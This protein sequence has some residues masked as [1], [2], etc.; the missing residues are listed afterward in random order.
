MSAADLAA[1][2]NAG[3]PQ[4]SVGILTADLGRMADELVHTD[5]MDGVFCPML[6]VGEPFVRAQ[7]TSLLKDV[8]LM[9]DEPLDKVAMFARAGADMITFQ[10]EAAR[11]PHRV[12]QAIGALA[13]END[14]SRGIIRGLAISPGTPL[15]V[16]PP[17]LD[18]LDYVML[19]AINPGW[20][21]QRFLASTQG[22][23]AQ[24]RAMVGASGREILVGI[25]GGVTKSNIRQVAALGADLVVTGSAVFDGTPD[26]EANA[27]LMLEGLRAGA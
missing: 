19:L 17:L 5:V 3:G 14:A 22:R 23:V 18:E 1:R 27:A 2:L 21:G 24:V 12:L 15:E 13:N 16:L 4:L 10:V 25:D 11:N 9:I 7:R 6:T 8:H 20:G 26:V